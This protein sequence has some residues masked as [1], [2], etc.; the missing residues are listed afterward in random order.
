MKIIDERENPKLARPQMPNVSCKGSYGELRPVE[1]IGYNEILQ[2]LPSDAIFK[3]VRP[4]SMEDLP[5]NNGSG[6][7]YGYLIHR[8]RLNVQNGSVYSAGVIK[9]FGIV[10]VNDVIETESFPNCSNEPMCYWINR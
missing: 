3:L 10:L 8:K 1:Y 4:T 7:S 9:D 2:Q 5:M 6:Q